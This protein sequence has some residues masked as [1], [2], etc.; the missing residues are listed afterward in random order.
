MSSITSMSNGPTESRSVNWGQ[1]ALV[2]LATVIAAVVAN[3]LVYFIGSAVVGYDP[4]F[5][6]LA[7]V[8]ATIL[9]TVVPAIVAVLLYAVLLRY[10]ADPARTFTIIATVVLVISL[11]P[12]FTYIPSV[13]GAT[14]GQTATLMVMHIVAAAV[15]V[16]TLTTFTRPQSRARNS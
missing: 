13:P 6:V 14:T 7:N 5:I 11:I 10:T 15:I 8:S 12:D 16:W 9:F 4:Q 2:G 1:Y 3:V